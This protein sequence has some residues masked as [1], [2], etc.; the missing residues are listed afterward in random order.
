MAKNYI[1]FFIPGRIRNN[2]DDYRRAFQLTAFTQLSPLFFIPNVIKWYKMGHNELALSIFIVMLLVALA[3]PFV[4]KATGSLKIMGN[5]IIAALVW[6]FTALP[7]VTGGIHSSSL[8]W[9]M[10]IPVFAITFVGFRSFVF[11]AGFMFLEIIIFTTVHITG[12]TLPTI[13]LSEIQMVEAQIANVVGPFLTMVIALTFGDRGLKKALEGHK[14]A[15]AAHAKAQQEQESLRKKSDRLA[16]QLELIFTKVSEH[17]VHLVDNVGKEMASLSEKTA[18]S[19]HEA[20]NLIGQTGDVVGETTRSMKKLVSQM[21]DISKTGEETSKIIKTIDEIAFQ[22]NLLALNAAVESARAGEAGAGFAV[23]ADEVR[24][25]AMRA[26]EA[27]RNTSDLI[28]DMIKRITTGSHLAS[29]TDDS[30]ARVADNVV[31]AVNLIDEIARFSSEQRRGVDTVNHIADEIKDL[32]HD[33]E[34]ATNTRPRRNEPTF[35]KLIDG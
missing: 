29:Q 31:R 4:L 10:V 15:A 21:E 32:V 13:E 9:N 27:A 5:F 19:A 12:Y 22:T 23:V 20:S 25:L 35:Q 17:S 1:D 16:Q 30:F 28:D 2:A 26:A 24:N 6:H 33:N 34:P 7:A 11:W 14:A 8:A 18:D 3:G